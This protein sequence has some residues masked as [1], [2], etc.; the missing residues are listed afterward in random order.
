VTSKVISTAPSAPDWERI[1]GDYRAGV[2]SLRE[3]ATRDGN[4]TEGA[5]RKRA[6]RDGWTR[7]LAAK[8]KAKADDLVRKDAVRKSSTQSLL[9]TATEREVIDAGAQQIAN[10]RLQHRTDIRR[11]RDLV[12]TLLGELEGQTAHNDMLQELGE[13]MRRENENGVDRLNDT[14]HKVIGLAGRVDSVKKLSDAL[15]N[16]VGMEREAYGLNEPEKPAGDLKELSDADLEQRI[17]DIESRSH[18]R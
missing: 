11:G 2:L 16:L 8:I 7:D 14:Y 1:E 13:L 4:V 6:K 3:I 5:I 18:P 17:R 10:V 9:S 12:I 15:K